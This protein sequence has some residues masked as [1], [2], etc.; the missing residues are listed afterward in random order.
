MSSPAVKTKTTFMQYDVMGSSGLE[1]GSDPFTVLRRIDDEIAPGDVVVL[2]V[3]GYLNSLALSHIY[4]MW[5]AVITR[6][7]IFRCVLFNAM[8]MSIAQ[9][10]TLHRI[11]DFRLCPNCENAAEITHCGQ[12]RNGCEASYE[13]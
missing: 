11:I 6:G 10:S 13:L 8:S 2:E 3:R 4:V 7:S 5:K 1:A 9:M 12:C